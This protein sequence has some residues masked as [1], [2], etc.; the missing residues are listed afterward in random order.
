MFKYE[1][2]QILEISKK[3]YRQNQKTGGKKPSEPIEKR[4]EN[5][6]SEEKK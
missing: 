6:K 5:E 2:F 1:N 4:V 3:N